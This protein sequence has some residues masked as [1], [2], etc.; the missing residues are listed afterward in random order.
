MLDGEK[1][2]LIH[3]YDKAKRTILERKE[4]E[5][6]FS[7][8]RNSIKNW[9]LSAITRKVNK[10]LDQPQTGPKSFYVRLRIII[11]AFTVVLS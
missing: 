3:R 11:T 7:I 5:L 10:I 2:Q 8:D 6:F 1:S 9:I 4:R